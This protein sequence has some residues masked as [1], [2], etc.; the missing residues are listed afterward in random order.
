M[1]EF[2]QGF[3]E[4]MGF[5]AAVD[6]IVGRRNRST[7]IEEWFEE[8]EMD[9]L[10][11]SLLVYIMEQTLNENDQCTMENMAAFLEKVLPAFQKDFS[12]K[13][14]YRLTEYMV[15]DIL[16][17][18]GEEK[19]YHVMDYEHGMKEIRIRLI[20]D[21]ITDGGKIVYQLTD[22]GYNLLFRTREVDKE[23]DFKLEQLKLKELLKRKNYK[24]ALRQSQELMNM[25]RQKEKELELFI[26]R[27]R[28]N[29]YT[30]DRGEHKKLLDETYHLLDEE[31]QGMLELK[32]QVER[33]EERIY[34]E[35]ADHTMEDEAVT[36][37]LRNLAL[38]RQNLTSVTVQQRNLI[39]K[40][41]EMNDI[42]EETIRDS[43][44]TAMVR[45]Y[46][47]QKEIMEPME[48]VKG[49]QIE[50]LWKLFVPL[51]RP[52]ARKQ[53]LLS[54]PYQPQ[55]KLHE[56]ET[57]E[58][59]IEEDV[60][61]EDRRFQEQRRRDFIH[62]KLMERMFSYGKDHPVFTFSEFYQYLNQHAEKPE[63]YTEE[64]RIF[65]VM[66]KLYDYKKIRK[67]EISV[68]TDSG[69]HKVRIL[70]DSQK[71]TVRMG[72]PLIE[73]TAHVISMEGQKTEMTIV[74]MG[75]PHAV[76][77]MTPEEG[78]WKTWDMKK[79]AAISTHSDFPEGINVELVQVYSETGMKV[80]VWERGSTETLSCGSGACAAAA[81]AIRSGRTKQKV[82]IEMPGGM[83]EVEW[84]E[85]G[86]LY[87][88]GGC[89]FVCEG[90]YPGSI[91]G[92]CSEAE[93]GK[94]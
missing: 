67:Q 84:K 28:Q 36:E 6:S 12:E 13:Q 24:H 29:I 73:E 42:Y 44:Y 69:I 65:L 1:L 61:E 66:L 11:F 54:M 37:A 81:A 40:R 7:E 14:I 21:K 76:I 31:Y 8:E 30:I 9:N 33:D 53:L 27:I 92:P 57:E 52:R 72:A 15:R 20:Q 35:Q 93:I 77:F 19:T 71:A 80:R 59:A 38:I 64:K 16:Q 22:Q 87:L 2:L 18:K 89:R 91:A 39:G 90:E 23:L 86:E 43:F 5:V 51:R 74:S 79:A 88:T 48:H 26:D 32:E 63:I 45:R 58:A 41:F 50:S 85:D 34:Q 47:F 49:E 62:V 46:D 68:E 75:N 4:R 56:E 3:Q 83:L 82:N 70:E 55:G 10:F 94:A 25:L 17:N 60:F 78:S